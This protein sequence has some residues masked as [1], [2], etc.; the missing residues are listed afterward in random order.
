MKRALS[1]ADTDAST[2]KRTKTDSD[3]GTSTCTG[4][5]DADT[6]SMSDE[7]TTKL[8]SGLRAEPSAQP[9]SNLSTSLNSE[10]V[11]SG[12]DFWAKKK[13]VSK[14]SGGVFSKDDL[15]NMFKGGSV[16]CKDGDSTPTSSSPTSSFLGSWAD[17]DLLKIAKSKEET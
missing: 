9:P 8:D 5:P 4:A 11:N 14:F 7:S 13:P 3:S 6:K 2:S 1:S 12:W 10:K 16:F 15:N 17:N